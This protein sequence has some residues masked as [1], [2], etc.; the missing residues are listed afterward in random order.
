MTS[1]KLIASF[2]IKQY[3]LSAFNFILYL[4]RKLNILLIVNTQLTKYKI[5]A[6]ADDCGTP[7]PQVVKRTTHEN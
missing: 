5:G 4:F 6:V 3:L 2:P 1:R 7:V